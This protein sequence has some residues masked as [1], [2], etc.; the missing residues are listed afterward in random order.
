MKIIYKNNK[1]HV[2]TNYTKEILFSSTNETK[3]Y[4]WT[5]KLLQYA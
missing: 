3:C 2:V 1:F 5:F 4:E